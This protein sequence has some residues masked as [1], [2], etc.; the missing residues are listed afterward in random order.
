MNSRKI[1]GAVALACLAAL[2]VAAQQ[3]TT[4]PSPAELEQMHFEAAPAPDVAGEPSYA[5]WQAAIRSFQTFRLGSATTGQWHEPPHRRG[6]SD[7]RIYHQAVSAVVYIF[8]VEEMEGN[9]I[10]SGASG[11]GTIL[12]TGE[13]LTAW[14]VVQG[15]ADSGNPIL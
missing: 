14:H 10:K 4:L 11:A 2:V 9:E 12:S 6:P 15:A 7:T 13:I 1:L 3:P 5:D 8:G